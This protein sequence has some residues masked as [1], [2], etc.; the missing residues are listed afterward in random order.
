RGRRVRRM[1]GRPRSVG[2]P[3]RLG[4]WP[5]RLALSR[6][7]HRSLAGHAR[8]GRRLARWLPYFEYGADEFLRADGCPEE[9]AARREAGLARLALRLAE[10]APRT[11]ELT[12]E[13]R[14]GLSDLA[15][16]DAYPVPYP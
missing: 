1:S 7:K 11:L 8:I 14:E 10:K 5:A 4:F 3:P 2:A 9:V 16:T 6:A 15:F 13:L 12:E